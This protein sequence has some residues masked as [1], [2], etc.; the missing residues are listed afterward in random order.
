M[1]K[2]LLIIGAII[3]G[4][5]S[6][7]CT[8]L[9][10]DNSSQ[11]GSQQTN[12]SASPTATIIQKT[13]PAATPTPQVPI[14]KYD[15]DVDT[16]TTCPI[17]EIKDWQ[18][19]EKPG[20]YTNT[21]TISGQKPILFQMYWCAIN[22]QTLEENIKHI[23]YELYID[24]TLV[25]EGLKHS[26]RAGCLGGGYGSYYEGVLPEWQPGEH[27]FIWVEH[28]DQKIHDGWQNYEPGEY[29]M[30]FNVTVRPDCRFCLLRIQAE[31][32]K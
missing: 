11:K 12:E 9:I 5:I 27:T 16:D 10:W 22:Q 23:R 13:I 28:I 7:S 19:P 4:I 2:A 8:A 6:G 20:S 18:G 24:G 14:H 15:P 29:R 26:D 3:I 21:V 30:I 1:K 17:C 25:R 31:K 32:T